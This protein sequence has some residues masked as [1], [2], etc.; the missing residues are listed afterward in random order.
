MIVEGC[1]LLRSS[2][3]R[4]QSKK[5]T[6]CFHIVPSPSAL[7]LQMLRLQ[8]HEYEYTAQTLQQDLSTAEYVVMNHFLKSRSWSLTLDASRVCYRRTYKCDK[9]AWFTFS[10]VNVASKL[11]SFPPNLI[12]S[13]KRQNRLLC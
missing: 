3:S 2:H 7:S 8:D 9:I 5:Q 10:W 12:S 11:Y 1:N 6:V 4:N 13:I